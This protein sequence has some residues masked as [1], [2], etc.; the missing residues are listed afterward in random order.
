[1]FFN[2]CVGIFTVLVFIVGKKRKNVNACKCFLCLCLFSFK[3][4]QSSAFSVSVSFSPTWNSLPLSLS[5]LLLPG[6]SSFSVSVSF[7]STWNSLPLPLSLFLQLGT[8]F[9]LLCFCL[10]SFNLEQSSSSSVSF[11]STWTV[12]LLCFCLL[13][14]NLEQ[15]SFSVS[16]SFPSTWNSLP[17]SLSLVLQPGT[18]LLRLFLT[19]APQTFPF[20]RN[21]FFL[22]EVFLCLCLW[23]LHLKHTAPRHSRQN[24]C[25]SSPPDLKPVHKLGM[26]T[27][28]GLLSVRHFMFLEIYGP[29]L[30]PSL[31]SA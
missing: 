9:V 19:L 29:S 30:Q 13:S 2:F 24:G 27:R 1:M 28:C 6:Q 16:V 7:P 3:L 10:L 26:S 31:V 4:E 25:I 21:N 8:V 17:L 22:L 23:P 15:S 20:T 5:P 11:P 14:F 12:F 18:V